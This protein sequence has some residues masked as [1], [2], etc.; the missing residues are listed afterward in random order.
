M[1]CRC[2]GAGAVHP[3]NGRLRDEFLNETLFVSLAHARIALAAWR[4]D[5]NTI[6]PHSGL[7]NLPPAVYAKLSDPAMQ[8][9]GTLRSLTG[10]APHPVAPPSPMGSNAEQTLLVAGGK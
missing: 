5:Y 6:R 2:S 9:D 8:R 7:G 1:T 10:F 4:L 3:I